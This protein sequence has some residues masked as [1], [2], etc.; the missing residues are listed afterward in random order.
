MALER[1]VSVFGVHSFKPALFSPLAPQAFLPWSYRSAGEGYAIAMW[2]CSGQRD[3]HNSGK[4]KQEY[5]NSSLNIKKIYFQYLEAERISRETV[6]QLGTKAKQ[7]TTRREG[8]RERQ[9]EARQKKD[10]AASESI[11]QKNSYVVW[12]IPDKKEKTFFQAPLVCLLGGVYHAKR[13]T[14]FHFKKST[15]GSI[16]LLLVTYPHC[17][18]CW[19][20]NSNKQHR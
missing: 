12:T 2:Q 6:K 7:L 3:T 15:A 4:D 17:L 13:I 1:T 18:Y 20:T 8:E 10:K 14:L 9:R 16:V 19:P 5:I 11:N